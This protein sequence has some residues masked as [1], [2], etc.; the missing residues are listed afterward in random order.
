MTE[1]TASRNVKISTLKFLQAVVFAK[2]WSWGRRP[3]DQGFSAYAYAE[4]FNCNVP[5]DFKICQQ[6]PLIVTNNWHLVLYKV[7]LS[8]TWVLLFNAYLCW[9]N[10]FIHGFINVYFNLI[11]TSYTRNHCSI[12]KEYHR[13]FGHGFGLKN[14]SSKKKSTWSP[15][16]F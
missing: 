7:E 10:K 16:I 13:N 14:C 3:H 15:L 12:L 4:V 11:C 1:G 9:T 5:K 2:R 6:S 8:R